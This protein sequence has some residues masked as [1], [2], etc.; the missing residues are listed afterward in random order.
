MLSV[1]KRQVDVGPYH[2]VLFD[3]VFILCW[4]W[5]ETIRFQ[6]TGTL[7]ICAWAANW[8]HWN[9]QRIKIKGA[10]DY[11]TR[12]VSEKRTL[13]RNDVVEQCLQP[14]AVQNKSR[15]STFRNKVSCTVIQLILC[16]PVFI[17]NSDLFVACFYTEPLLMSGVCWGPHR[18]LHQL[19]RILTTKLSGPVDLPTYS[20]HDC[21]NSLHYWPY[22]L[23][24]VCSS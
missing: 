24:A 13:K 9:H 3:D 23:T 2:I 1:C 10:N 7:I 4:C 5:I 19:S 8:R 21:S 15:P 11:I 14:P 16:F 22:R 6:N 12:F 18:R 20:I 17:I